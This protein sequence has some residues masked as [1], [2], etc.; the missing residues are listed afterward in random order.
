MVSLTAARTVSL[1]DVDTFPLGQD[2]VIADESGACSESLTITIIPGSGTGDT[3][4]GD[5]SIV[6]TSPYQAVRF[7]RGAANLWI[8]L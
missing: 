6:L 1:P 2:L 7:R 8:R 3:I 4:A 5:G